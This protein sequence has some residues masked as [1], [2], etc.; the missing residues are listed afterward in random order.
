MVFGGF[1]LR[2]LLSEVIASGPWIRL[3]PLVAD[4]AHFA[5]VESI[6]CHLQIAF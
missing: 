4:T 3:A 2:G 6:S 5:P 1:F